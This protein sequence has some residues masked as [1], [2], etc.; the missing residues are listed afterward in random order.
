MNISPGQRRSSYLCAL[1][2]RVT[3]SRFTR[4]QRQSRSV[5][6]SRGAA[7]LV[8]LLLSSTRLRSRFKRLLGTGSSS[9][10]TR[11]LLE[12]LRWTAS[13]SST[14]SSDGALQR[15]PRRAPKSLFAEVPVHE[16]RGTRASARKRLHS[17]HRLQS[18]RT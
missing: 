6:R 16:G 9:L 17:H 14:L 11:S 2:Q 4:A 7:R 12:L 18:R 8:Q 1:L 3:G 13:Q 15:N 10:S 5:L